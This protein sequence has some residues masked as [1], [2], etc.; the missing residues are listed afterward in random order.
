MTQTSAMQFAP[1]PGAER[2]VGL[3]AAE[4]PQKD[5]LCGAFWGALAF[6][7]ARITVN[8][9]EV[10]QDAIALEAG[11]ILSASQLEPLPYGDP[12]RRDYRVAFPTV[13]DPAQ[14]GTS[15]VG[16]VH[17]LR[18]LA[19]DGAAIIPIAGP[20]TP[21]AVRAMFDATDVCRE[22]CTLIANIA[23]R[24]LW[25]SRTGPHA[26]FSYLVTGDDSDGDEP[27]WDIG[28]FVG[29]LG[30]IDGPKGALVVVGDTYRVLG[31]Q[32]LHLQPIE[33]FAR[34]LERTGTGHPSGAIIVA[35]PQDGP[36]IEGVLLAAGLELDLWDNGTPYTVSGAA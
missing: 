10:D 26:A 1:I 28:H 19:G 32:G 33:R 35:S 23:T 13:E 5:E 20:W 2:L 12:G 29:L 14:S 34:A 17:A 21:A 36:D 31:W 6:R 25:G 24:Y 22:S 4:L 27:D 15:A 18:E 16:L 30:H 7:L 3:H 8:G 11:T 9:A